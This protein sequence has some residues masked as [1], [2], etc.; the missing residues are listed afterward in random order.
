MEVICEF[1]ICDAYID[2]YDGFFNIQLLL[3][4]HFFKQIKLFF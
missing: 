2:N 4:K 1:Q 3:E